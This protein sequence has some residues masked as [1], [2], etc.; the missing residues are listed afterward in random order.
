[1]LTVRVVNSYAAVSD[2]VSVVLLSRVDCK[3]HKQQCYP[4]EVI[5]PFQQ[6]GSQL[7]L[8]WHLR[9][10]ARRNQSRRLQILRLVR[11][12]GLDN[13]LVCGLLRNCHKR[14]IQ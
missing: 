13:E 1:M 7:T 6:T 14:E 2:A 3:I 4:T 9:I 5:L 12:V 10:F 11:A 8:P